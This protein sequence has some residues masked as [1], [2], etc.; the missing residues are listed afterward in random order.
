MAGLRAE[1]E[2]LPRAVRRGGVEGGRARAVWVARSLPEVRGI[3]TMASAGTS[4]GSVLHEARIRAELLG[5]EVVVHEDVGVAG[6][7]SLTAVLP[8][9]APAACVVVVPG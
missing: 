9:L 7:P 8:D 6:I 1:L 2:T 5:A 4:D 3:V